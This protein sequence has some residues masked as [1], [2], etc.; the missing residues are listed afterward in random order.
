MLLKQ[1][2]C[3][4]HHHQSGKLQK[5]AVALSAF[6]SLGFAGPLLA[7]PSPQSVAAANDASASSTSAA[8]MMT[9]PVLVIYASTRCG[10]QTLIGNCSQPALYAW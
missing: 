9:M 8:D 6:L 5:L 1:R 3:H 10:P 7:A 2:I 4:Q